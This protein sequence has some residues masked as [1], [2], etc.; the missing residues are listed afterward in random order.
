MRR[1][2]FLLLCLFIGIGVATAQTMKITGNVISSEDQQPVIGA[3]VVV[4]GTTIGTVTDFEGNFSLDVPRDAKMIFISYVGLKTKEVPV[5]SVINVVL[6]S[7]SK[8]LDEVVVTAMGLTREKKALGYALQEVKSDEFNMKRYIKNFM[9]AMMIGATVF[10]SSC[11][12]SFE[13]VNTD[14]DSPTDV[15][16]TNLLA[17]SLYYTSYRLYDRWFAMDE[18]MTFCGYASKMTYIDESRYN[19]RTGVQ[20]TNWEYLY[21]ILNN[22]KDIEKR[23]TFNETPNMLNVSKVMQVHLMQV[24]TDRWRDVPYTDAAKMTDGVLQPKYDKQEDIYPGLLATLKEAADG[25]ADGGSDDLGEGDLLFGGDIEKWQRYCNSM[26]LRLA[27]RIS[28]VSPALA[29]ETVEEVM[30]NP[31]KYP[32]MESNDDNA[33]FWWIGTDPNYY[34]PMAD[35]Y[36]TRKTEY[37]AADVIVDHM[38]TREDPRRSSYFQPT[39]ESVEAG[40]P[41]YVGYTIGAKANAVASKYSIWGARFFT[42]LAG[43]SPYM[44]VAEPWFCVAEASMLGWNTGISAEDAYNKAVTY[45]MEENSVS[46]EDIADYLANAGKFTNDKKQIY[47]EEWV[48]MF[49]QGMEGWSLYRRTGVPDNLYP[50]PGRPA[51]YSN[52]NVPP[53]RSPY[54]DKERNL[55]NANCAPFDA[56]VVDN[57]W[58]KQMWWDTRTGVH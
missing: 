52:H 38:N 54:P 2:T 29:K 17:Y 33:F 5:A 27:M 39:K 14:P 7:D 32:I 10:G 18:P 42:D 12:D 35:G 57:L 22:L 41:K 44:R 24:A 6:D 26:R 15:P 56:E 37:C 4:K 53:F 19:F 28:E 25:F 46:A 48:A 47:Y 51:N 11:T 20:D 9:M 55:N 34:E 8:A 3:A 30:G 40:E 31:T 23:A 13:E 58:G 16:T 43:F 49:K 36:R 45:S 50:A 21:R 1:L